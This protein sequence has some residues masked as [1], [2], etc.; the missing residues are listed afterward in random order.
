MGVGVL[1]NLPYVRCKAG[2]C[3]SLLQLDNRCLPMSSGKTVSKSSSVKWILIVRTLWS[4]CVV[5]QELMHVN[6]LEL[7]SEHYAV[8]V[9]LGGI[10]AFQGPIV[11]CFLKSMPSIETTLAGRG[12][13]QWHCP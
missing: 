12:A 9:A 2:I 8:I 13:V 5:T 10:P 11:F 7:A 3:I 6:H 4:C 1:Q